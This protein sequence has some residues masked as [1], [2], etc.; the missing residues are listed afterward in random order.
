M[1]STWD[2]TKE[3]IGN[4]VMLNQLIIIVKNG[5]LLAALNLLI[6]DKVQK[7]FNNIFFFAERRPRLVSLVPNC[8]KHFWDFLEENIL[9]GT[10]LEKAFNRLKSSKSLTFHNIS[11][12]IIKFSSE[13]IFCPLKYILAF[14]G[15]QYIP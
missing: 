10:Q 9:Q 3:V 11:A 8:F 14:L 2:T 7:N 13:N 4:V 6:K 5:W 1:R 15:K 12:S